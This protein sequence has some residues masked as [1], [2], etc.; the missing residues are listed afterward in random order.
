MII[1]KDKYVYVLKKI[2]VWRNKD[3]RVFEE[4]HLVMIKKKEGYFYCL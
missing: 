2:F 3:P 1:L 4:K